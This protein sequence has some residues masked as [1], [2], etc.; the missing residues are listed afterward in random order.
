MHRFDL[1]ETELANLVLNKRLYAL[2]KQHYG[3]FIL[4]LIPFQQAVAFSRLFDDFLEHP[5]HTPSLRHLLFRPHST[6]FVFEV[7]VLARLSNITS[8][9]IDINEDG[10][11]CWARTVNAL[12]NLTSLRALIIR[13]DAGLATSPV[14]IS[15]KHHLPS[16]RSLEFR[17]NAWASTMPKG[18]LSGDNTNFRSLRLALNGSSGGVWDNIPFASLHC[19]QIYSGFGGLPEVEG[20]ISS[21]R[22]A[23][24]ANL[25]R[26]P[27]CIAFL[28]QTLTRPLFSRRNS[29]LLSPSDDSSS[30]RSRTILKALK[31]VPF[32]RLS[33]RTARRSS[34]SLRERM[35]PSSTSSL[36]SM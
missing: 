22:S 11:K 17:S 32:N 7:K 9:F 13:D 25:V 16:L 6:T 20:L 4:P 14:R 35:F 36:R 15:L 30:L 2:A 28:F 18:L 34:S 23:V 12:P 19:L 26:L 29:P 8:L 33:M 27:L 3:R 24:D 10:A 5:N 31:C 21:L 1:C